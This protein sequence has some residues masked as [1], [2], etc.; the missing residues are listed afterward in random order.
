MVGFGKRGCWYELTDASLSN[1]VPNATDISHSKSAKWFD[2]AELLIHL[3]WGKIYSAYVGNRQ[4]DTWCSTSWC[5]CFL[6]QIKST[7][8]LFSMTFGSSKIM[9]F[10]GGQLEYGWSG[11]IC[12]YWGETEHLSSY[13]ELKQKGQ[14]R[15]WAL[16]GSECDTWAGCY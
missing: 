8:S 13:F 1:R 12:Q 7:L 5:Q 9:L 3:L 6:A 11:I 15:A 2:R 16:R 14:I 10:D 4:E